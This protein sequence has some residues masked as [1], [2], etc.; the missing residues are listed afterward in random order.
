MRSYIHFDTRRLALAQLLR[1]QPESV[2]KINHQFYKLGSIV[3]QVICQS[4]IHYG[5]I[6]MTHFVKVEYRGRKYGVRE[7]SPKMQKK[8]EIEKVSAVNN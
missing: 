2:E 3:F 6:A 1:I 5:G 8:Y 4:E 7:L